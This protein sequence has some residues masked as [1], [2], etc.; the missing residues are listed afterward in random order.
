MTTTKIVATHEGTLRKKYKAAGWLKID[1]ALKRLITADAAR[2]IA[3]S[4]VALDTL[5]PAKAVAGRP[6]TFKAAIDQ[7]FLAHN[8]PDYVLILGGPDVVPHQPLKNPV[9][10]PRGEDRDKTVPSDLP[11]ACD[12]P[13]GTAIEDFLGPSRVVGRLPDLP[14]ATKPALLVGLIDAAARAKSAPTAG[15]TF[16]GVSCD[17]WKGSTTKSLVKLFGAGSKPHLSPNEGPDWTSGE[18]G[19]GWH[20]INCHGAPKDPQFYGQKGDDYPV[21][22]YS[23]KLS[24]KVAVGTVVAAECCYGA[25]VYNPGSGDTGIAITYLQEGA[26]GYLG[27]TNIAYGPAD[28]TDCADLVC[29]YFLESARARAS[30]G[31]ALLEARQKY[32]AGA[33]PVDPVALKTVGQFLLLGDPSLHPVASTKSTKK[34][35]TKAKTE[36]RSVAA[37]AT[38]H[39]VTR[40]GLTKTAELLTRGADSVKTGVRTQSG[41]AVRSRIEAVAAHAGLTTKGPVRAFPVAAAADPVARKFVTRGTAKSAPSMTIRFHVAF[42]MPASGGSRGRPKAMARATTGARATRPDAPPAGVQSHALLLAREQG[43]KVTIK[44]LFAR[45]APIQEH[46]ATPLRR[47]GD[48]ESLRRRHEESTAGSDAQDRRRRARV[49]SPRR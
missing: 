19:P 43:G 10:D 48:Q 31:R 9:F 5:A 46:D 7:A 38:T 15:K 12:A 45:L 18:L 2:G 49:A 32:I 44:K 29:R 26:M 40:G 37:S 14:R 34:S 3:T 20:F 24:S 13:Y 47:P 33:V 36:A 27:S 4:V 6:K 8:R 35:T 25:E 42:A 30:L 41:T 23:L 11:Y 39:A 1:A 22:H 16:F 21:A 28:V 17:K